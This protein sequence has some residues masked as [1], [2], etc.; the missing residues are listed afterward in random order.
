MCFINLLMFELVFH[1]GSVETQN[2]SFF[3]NDQITLIVIYNL[4]RRPPPRAPKKI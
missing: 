1:R 2:V 4:Y 3:K